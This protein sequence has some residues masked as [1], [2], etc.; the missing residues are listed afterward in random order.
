M[1]FKAR[2]DGVFILRNKN[3]IIGYAIFDIKNNQL[4]IPYLSVVERFRGNGFGNILMN[5]IIGFGKSKKCNSFEL[6]VFNENNSAINLYK[7]FGFKVAG[8]KDTF[9]NMVKNL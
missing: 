7:K 8:R 9:L 2:N 1:K 6:D 3:K 5:K 4:K